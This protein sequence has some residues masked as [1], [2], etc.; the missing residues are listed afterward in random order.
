M[1]PFTVKPKGLRLGT[2]LKRGWKLRVSCSEAC[3]FA[4]TLTPAKGKKRVLARG[5]GRTTKAGTTT[6][7]LK[8]TKAG[9]RALKAK[10][11]TRLRAAVVA[12]DSAGQ[13]VTASRVVRARR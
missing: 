5:A 2:L 6:I 11:S 12:R 9:R 8:V 7:R 13:R 1:P 10:K 4:L 3:R